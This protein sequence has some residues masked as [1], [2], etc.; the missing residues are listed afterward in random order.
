MGCLSAASRPP[1]APEKGPRHTPAQLPGGR[2]STTARTASAPGSIAVNRGSGRVAGTAISASNPAARRETAHTA[3]LDG[4]C[5]CLPRG[6]GDTS[7][8]DEERKRS[9]AEETQSRRA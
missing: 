7:Y 1:V 4:G 6:H 3:L 8:Q 2:W 9:D 5:G